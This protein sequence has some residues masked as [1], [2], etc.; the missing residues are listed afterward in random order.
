MDHE[1]VKDLFSEY[2]DGDLPAGKAR[3]VEEHLDSC[4]GCRDAYDEFQESLGSLRSLNRS[5]PPPDFE[6]KLKRR[7]RVRSRGRFFSEASQPHVVTRVPFELISL[8]LILIAMSLLYLMT[9]VAEIEAPP[10]PEDG[11]DSQEEV[12]GETPG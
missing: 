1:T 12:G 11:E 9:L 7:I 8:I 10:P 2:F 6:Q 3:E 5:A 4:P